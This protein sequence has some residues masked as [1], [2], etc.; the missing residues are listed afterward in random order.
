MPR[1]KKYFETLIPKSTYHIY[2]R[3]NNREDLFITEEMRFFFLQKIEF[4]LSDYYLVH[5]YCL[6][7]N[8]FHLLVQTKSKIQILKNLKDKDNA[9][10]TNLEIEFIECD[11]SERDIVVSKLFRTQFVRLFT[12]YSVTFNKVNSRTGNLFNRP[13]KRK[14]VANKIYFKKLVIYIHKNPDKH[15]L[16][17]KFD[18]YYWSSYLEYVNQE[19]TFISKSKTIK[20]FN[21]V[22]S[23]VNAH[24]KAIDFKSISSLLLDD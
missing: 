18:E 11:E 1:N 17:E 20:L 4:Y 15:G 8:H 13:Y 22:S 12:S 23:F 19:D 9:V 7:D 5:A 21:G 2:N 24:N 3:T 16:R 14:I 6:L 10:L